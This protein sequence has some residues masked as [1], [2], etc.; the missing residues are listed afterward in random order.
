MT[1]N[2][3]LFLL[4]V[5]LLF[6]AW[7]TFGTNTTPSGTKSTAL[8]HIVV[9]WKGATYLVLEVA[10]EALQFFL[11]N[12][13]QQKF[14]SFK[15]LEQYLNDEKQQLLLAMN[16]GMY[17]PDQNNEPQGL[18][19]EDETVRKALEPLTSH[20]P[21]KTNF[22]LHPNGVFYIQTNGVA[23]VQANE[24]FQV[25]Q[26]DKQYQGIK[27]A[28]QSGPMLVI[29]KQ[30]HP[31]FTPNSKNKH[32][33]N[34]VGILPNGKVALVLSQEQICFHDM[35]TLFRDRLNCEN[36]LYLDGF[37]SRVY[38]PALE[39][40]NDAQQGNFGMIIGVTTPK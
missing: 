1:K 34:A 28:T 33:R 39:A 15:N 2:I 35:A 26:E 12:K 14:R 38:Y 29:D 16:G 21:K 5:F 24:A 30:L 7:P 13:E 20:R 40:Y 25:V 8:H 19:I 6:L 3:W 17:L 32:F 18:Y 31:A 10:P 23:V 37:V 4:G 11:E 27:Y 9:E 22:Y 36:A